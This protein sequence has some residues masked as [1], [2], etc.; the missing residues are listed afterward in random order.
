MIAFTQKL[1]ALDTSTALGSVAF[2]DRGEV[3]LEDE[4][5][6]SNAHGESLLP[7][8]DAAFARVGWA[9]K[10]VARWVVGIGPGSFTGVRIGV[11]TVKGIQIATGAEIVGVT[12]LDAILA[13]SEPAEVLVAALAAMRGE[14]FACSCGAVERPPVCLKVADVPPWIAS[15]GARAPKVVG[16]APPFCEGTPPR[17]RFVAKAADGR[18]PDDP[19]RLEPLYV[20]PPEITLPASLR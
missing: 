13:A 6:V 4:R 11:A 18:P 20:R 17:A 19:D 9:P 14:V 3:V 8:I 7:M 10:D 16:E 1:V 12:S 5:R 15:I 2:F